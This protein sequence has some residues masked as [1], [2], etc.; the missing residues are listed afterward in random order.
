MKYTGVLDMLLAWRKEG[1]GRDL[2]MDS[3]GKEVVKNRIGRL[4]WMADKA[5]IGKTLL[6]VKF[7]CGDRVMI[8]K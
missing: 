6:C 3:R 5:L 4:G 1:L 7:L 2:K 8:S